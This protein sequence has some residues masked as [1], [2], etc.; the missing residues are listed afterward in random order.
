M[1]KFDGKLEAIAHS[2][3]NA[4]DLTYLLDILIDQIRWTDHWESILEMAN[5]LS[6]EELLEGLRQAVMVV[7]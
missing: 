3:Y 1:L 2:Q 6:F 4:S 5:E 7:L